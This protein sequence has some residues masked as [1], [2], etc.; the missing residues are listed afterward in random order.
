MEYYRQS[1]EAAMQTLQTNR[2]G[3]SQNEAEK[4]QARYGK[5]KLE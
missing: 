2:D 4:R 5:N 3:L 1:G